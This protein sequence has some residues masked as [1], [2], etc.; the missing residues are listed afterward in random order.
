LI[1]FY[2]RFLKYAI[3][4]DDIVREDRHVAELYQEAMEEL[5]MRP[6]E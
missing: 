5:K 6:K 1:F 3:Q 4:C 2:Q